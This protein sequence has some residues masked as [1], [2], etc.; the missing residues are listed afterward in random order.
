MDDHQWLVYSRPGVWKPLQRACREIS[1]AEDGLKKSLEKAM[2]TLL[3]ITFF[4][5][6]NCQKSLSPWKKHTLPC[7]TRKVLG[8]FSGTAENS[9]L[10]GEIYLLER[11]H[12]DQSPQVSLERWQGNWVGEWFI[13]LFN[14]CHAGWVVS[15]ECV[16]RGKNKINTYN[17]IFGCSWQKIN[18]RQG[19]VLR[20]FSRKG[21]MLYILDNKEKATNLTAIL[22]RWLKK[23][24]LEFT[25]C[26]SLKDQTK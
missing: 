17:E 1:D 12:Q 5:S 10:V 11:L 2:T 18:F 3:Q 9:L 24:L 7:I 26:Q 20:K 21:G 15:M 13:R 22:D 4:W 25:N 8:E 14:R 16:H 6:E 23:Q 19:V